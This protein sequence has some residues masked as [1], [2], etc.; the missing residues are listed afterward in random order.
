MQPIFKPGKNAKIKFKTF[1]SLPFI[2]NNFEMLIDKKFW[3]FLQD[4]N[5]EATY[6]SCQESYK[7]LGTSFCAILGIIYV[8]LSENCLKISTGKICREGGSALT[9]ICS[10]EEGGRVLVF[11]PLLI[12]LISSFLFLAWIRKCWKG[13]IVKRIGE[14]ENVSNIFP[15]SSHKTAV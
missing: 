1:F 10:C 9:H 5:H 14:R 8:T 7:T 4:W 13:E 11:P 12:R 2:Q 6:F 3:D 15:S